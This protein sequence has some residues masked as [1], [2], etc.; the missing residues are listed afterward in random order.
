VDV[1][2]SDQSLAFVPNMGQV[3]SQ[4]QYEIRRP[5]SRL[6][7]ADNAIGV[8]LPATDST[9]GSVVRLEFAG[10]DMAT[11]APGETSGG[12]VNYFVGNDPQQ[13]HEG[14]PTYD[15]VTYPAL[16]PGISLE[17]GG[18]AGLLKGTFVVQPGSDPAQI[19]WRYAGGTPALAGDGSLLVS[20]PASGAEL[21]TETAPVAWQTVDSER[22]TVAASYVLHDNGTVGF[23]LGAYDRSLPLVI[24]PT[25]VYS[26]YLGGSAGEC[27]FGECSIATDAAGNIYVAGSV[28]SRDFPLLNP[29]YDFCGREPGGDIGG[30]SGGSMFVTKFNADGTLGYSTYFG[31]SSAG[32]SLTGI[33]ADDAGKIYVTGSGA[34]T[35]RDPD[36]TKYAFPVVG[37]N[38]QGCVPEGSTNCASIDAFTSWFDASGSL[39]F[40]T[41]I[42]GGEDRE[43]AGHIAVDP[44][45]NVY[46]TGATESSDFPAS[47]GAFQPAYGGGGDDVYIV[48]YAPDGSIIYSSY[49]GG[50][51]GEG[52]GAIAADSSGNAYVVG[53]TGSADFPVAN[54]FCTESCSGPYVSKISADGSQLLFSTRFQEAINTSSANAVGVDAA[55]NIYVGG[56]GVPV[57]DAYVLKLSSEGSQLL[58][59]TEL[60]GLDSVGELAVDEQGRVYATGT[61]DSASGAVQRA[62][63]AALNSSGQLIGSIELDGQED[64]DSGIDI[65]IDG[66][67][68]IYLIGV[69]GSS[70]FPTTDGTGGTLPAYDSTLD[71]D[72]DVFVMKLMLSETVSGTVSAGAGATFALENDSTDT[73]I[74]F[75]PGAL[76]SDADVTLED[77]GLAPLESQSDDNPFSILFDLFSLEGQQ[78]GT[79]VDVFEGDD[80]VFQVTITYSEAVES[81]LADLGLQERDLN[82]YFN[83]DALPTNNSGNVVLPGEEGFPYSGYTSLLPCDGCSLDTDANTIT[84][85]LNQTGSFMLGVQPVPPAEVTISGSSAITVAE[86]AILTAQVTP[87]LT[88]LPIDYTWYADEQ[89]PVE[90]TGIETLTNTVA[91]G[92][93]TPGTRAVT[94]TADNGTSIVTSSVFSVNVTLTGDNGGDEPCDSPDSIQIIDFE[95]IPCETPREG[96][97]ISD[98]FSTTT[99]VSF[100]L[101]GGGHPVLADVGGDRT[102]FIGPSDEDGNTNDT[103]APGQNVGQYFL[104]DDG[105]LDS[106]STPLIVT[107]D[108]PTAEASGFVLD[109]DGGETYTI[110]ARDANGDI[111]ETVTISDDDPE[112]GDGLATYWSFDR[113]NADIVSLRFVGEKPSGL[114]GLGFDNF[115]ARSITPG[116][117]QNTV[118]LPYITRGG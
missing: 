88:T 1:P 78:G 15:S 69:T 31:S 29:S 23:A 82:L 62:Y 47:A 35:E 94:V 8:V 93:D 56:F 48:K 61:I 57:I 64:F 16:Y 83:P 110:E 53:G 73:E 5:D 104:T 14:I 25:I 75:L 37:A 65:D 44:S 52:V 4:V 27:S 45:G 60:D 113:E 36:T 99:G 41:F 102:A 95:T 11:I 58:Y 87:D 66:I 109:V 21:L 89:E 98:Q 71:G 100:R 22:V 85:L 42:S 20:D 86:T 30:C 49:L 43:D 74:E 50:S 116:N 12:V 105:D 81:A 108:P 114:F 67:G 112:T 84:V 19:R 6:F 40:S 90:Q 39:Y 80:D 111:L 18:Q 55:G 79:N 72:I 17:Y 96:L 103:V 26:T 97:V 9:P 54:P 32:E 101:E 59:E 118:Y 34:L 91:F 51:A 13:W 76:S 117:T 3:G 77:F 107:Y 2:L 10:A 38:A 33:A 63:M 46:V 92:W 28:G 7:F 106:G 24:D 115:N 70:D 68:G